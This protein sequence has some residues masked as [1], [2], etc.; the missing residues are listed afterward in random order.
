MGLQDQKTGMYSVSHIFD[1]SREID[2]DAVRDHEEAQACRSMTQK[3]MEILKDGRRYEVMMTISTV[4]G[5]AYPPG[6][7][8]DGGPTL[9]CPLGCPNVFTQY[10][11]NCSLIIVL[12][13]PKDAE[14]GE[15]VKLDAFSDTQPQFQ[16]WML[17][18]P[19]G[20]REFERC[21]VGWKR[22]V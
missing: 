16:P 9:A 1:V 13:D 15:I 7:S 5:G 3:L 12:V 22:I 10:T 20:N 4:F 21:Q 18:S 6:A 8:I 19:D 2:G 14:I 17:Y 11:T